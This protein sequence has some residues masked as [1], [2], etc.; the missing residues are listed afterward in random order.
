[1]RISDWSSDVCSSDLK[2]ADAVDAAGWMHTGDLAVLDEEGY[3]NIVGRVKDMVIRGGENLFPREIEEYL[4][5]HPNVQDVQV[6]GI[7]DARYGE[8]LCARIVPKPRSEEHRSELQSL[9]RNSY[10]V[11]WLQ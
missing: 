4:Y 10:A 9:M 7:P 5:R 8:E 6:F 2:T 11:F 1:M 3:C